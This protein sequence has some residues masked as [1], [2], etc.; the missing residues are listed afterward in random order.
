[1]IWHHRRLLD[2]IERL[3][4]HEMAIERSGVDTKVSQHFAK[5]RVEEACAVTVAFPNS[6]D[7]T[8]NQFLPLAVSR[9]S[10]HVHGRG[11]RCEMVD[12]VVLVK[13]RETD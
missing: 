3:Q 11:I 7:A 12:I 5:G 2:A 4:A 8:L 9:S 1:M 13:I 6:S 10:V